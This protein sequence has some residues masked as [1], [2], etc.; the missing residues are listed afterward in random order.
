M[1]KYL[2][3]TLL[4]IFAGMAGIYFIVGVP[5][6]SPTYFSQVNSTYLYNN[7]DVSIKNIHIFAFYFV[8]QNRSGNISDEW[9]ETIS[10]GLA[11]LREFHSLQFRNLSEISYEVFPEPVVGLGDNVFYD[12]ENT[13]YGNPHAMIN[14]SEELER[15]VFREDGD[16]YREGFAKF[17]DDSYPILFIMYEGVGAVGGVINDSSK[18][19]ASEIA[20]ELNLPESVVYIV[21]VSSV[22]GFFLV[23]REIVEGKYGANGRAILAHEFYHTIG[24][25]DK[26]SL[27]TGIVQSPDLM[28]LGRF[29]PLENAYLS[30]ESLAAFGL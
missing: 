18:E 29:R 20:A 21:G 15:R 19:T 30:R 3:L 26:Y 13:N 8:P 12:T 10:A 25:E 9:N 11:N 2:V 1:F 7:P 28:G 23:N 16:L 17:K 5:R 27:E 6:I 4:L 24:L 14:I 22:N